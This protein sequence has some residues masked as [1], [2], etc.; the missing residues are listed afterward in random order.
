MNAIILAAG[1]GSRLMPLTQ[2]VPK[3]M[4]EYRN[5]KII[6]YEIEALRDSHIENIAVVGGYLYDILKDY[7]ISKDIK[8]FYN[9]PDYA[10]TNMVA[11]LFCAREFMQECIDNKEDLIISYADI[12]Y[13]KESIMKLQKSK[14]DFAILVDTKW[15]D[16]WERRFSDPLSDAETLKLRKDSV[17]G[18]CVV[19]LGKKPTSYDDIDGQYMGLFKFSHNFLQKVLDFYDNLDRNAYY[20]GKDFNNMYMTSFLQGIIDTYHNAKA[21][22]VNGGWCEIDCKSDLEIAIIES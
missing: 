14:D 11:T 7:L 4:V 22:M 15:R 1:F 12:V 9:N 2:N 20:D 5:K 6:D 8:R 10:C 13:F 18:D 3:C 19:E 17:Q 21:V 16:L